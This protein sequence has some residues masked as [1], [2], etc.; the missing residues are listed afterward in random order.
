MDMPAFVAPLTSLGP[1]SIGAVALAE[2]LF[3]VVPSH[4]VLIALGMT[5]VADRGDLVATIVATSIGSTIGSFC[6]YGLGWTLG[7][8]R[9]EA[10]MTRFGRYLCLSP[11]LYRRM[12]S[13]YRR[14]HF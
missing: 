13:A 3:P 7:P 11:P 14:N 5:T 9:S 8:W 2:K 10:L 1:L 4:A 12:T 6:W